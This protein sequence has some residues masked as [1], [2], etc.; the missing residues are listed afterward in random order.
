M[1]RDQ[2]KAHFIMKHEKALNIKLRADDVHKWNH[3]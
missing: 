3:F 2:N 1:Q